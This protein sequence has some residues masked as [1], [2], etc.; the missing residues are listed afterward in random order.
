VTEPLQDSALPDAPP[1]E[2]AAPPRPG[3]SAESLTKVFHDARTGDVKAADGIT[4]TCYHGEVFGL[5]GPNGAGKSTTLRMLSTVLRPTSG[6][7]CVA[8]HDILRAPLEVRRSIG[9]LSS[10]TGLY[11]RLTARETLQYFGR[12]HGLAPDRLKARVAELFSV[13]GI[14]DFANVRCEKL[15]TG[16]RQK[17]SIARAIVHDPE[18]LI[19]DEPT[20]G[21]D[22]LVARTMIRFVEDCRDRGKCIIFSTHI[23]SEVERLCD[24]LAIIHRG[25]LRAVG[26]LEDLRRSTGSRYV[27]EIFMSLVEE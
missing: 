16:M 22:V 1:S 19:L 12:L 5:L 10:S 20:L 13:F 4:F 3:I 11:G 18:I 2:L 8:G 27:E 17:V 14:E 15:S 21:L 9:Y 23:L 26:T 24:R 6:T 25:R 7:A